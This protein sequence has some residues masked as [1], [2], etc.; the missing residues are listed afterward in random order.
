MVNMKSKPSKKFAIVFTLVLIG[1]VVLY[2]FHVQPAESLGPPPTE[3]SQ[4]Y[5]GTSDESAEWVIQTKDGGY[6]IAGYT[7]SYG[8]GDVDLLLVK[9]D[10]AG[11]VQWDK[12]YGGIGDD[13]VESVVQTSDGGYALAGITNSFGAG[14]EDFWL[15]KTDSSGE[16]LW[17]KTFGGA[18]LDWAHSVVQTNDGGYLLAGVTNSSVASSYDALLVKT[19]SA[20]NMQWNR[21]YGGTNYEEARSLVRTSDEGYA[22]AG[23]TSSYGAGDHDF[24]LVK[25]DSSGNMQWNKT[26]GGASTEAPSSVVQ[27]KDGGYALVGG[28]VSY[29]GAPP[30]EDFW[31][32]KTDSSGDMLWSRAYGGTGNDGASSV[33]QTSDGGYALVGYTYSYGADQ[34]ASYGTGEANIWL[35]KTDS[36]GNMQWSKPYGG[37]GGESASS[38]VQTSDEGYVVAGDARADSAGTSDFW[39]VKIADEHAQVE[40]GLLTVYVG[41]ALVAVGAATVATIIYVKR[42]KR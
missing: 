7:Y 2:A 13:Y 12:T 32:V 15:V 21:T 14:R 42:F 19:D 5:G 29:A 36:S 38:V 6:A 34:P 30:N 28:T 4:T 39:L 26:Y 40:N 23:S 18:G 20:G 3:W 33:I 22:F 25:T 1:F 35:V 17:S 16:M 9:T 37:N 31:L 24:W 10:S 11:Q 27:T 8:A 41:V